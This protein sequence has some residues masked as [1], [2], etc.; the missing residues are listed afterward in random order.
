M[1]NDELLRTD[2]DG[3]ATLTLNRPEAMN[4]LTGEMFEA[5]AEAVTS[6]A[7]APDEVRCV[8]LRGAGGS[9]CAGSDVKQLKE[10]I[11]KGLQTDAVTYAKADVITAL[12]ALPQPVLGAVQGRCYTGGMELIL[13]CDII[14]AADDTRFADTHAKIGGR[15]GWG[16]PQRLARRVGAAAAKEIM[17]TSTP[18]S[19][20]DALRIGLVNR[21]VPAAELVDAVEALAADIVRNPPSSVN[22]LKRVVDEGAAL[23]LDE[24]LAWERTQRG[25]DRKGP[26]RLEEAER[27]MSTGGQTP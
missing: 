26:L 16:L 27:S 17:F 7:A 20:E 23:P 19:A 15:A 11:A 1:A 12:A 6:I 8:I 18:F 24:A 9:F 25:V 13:A 22:W 5:L 2:R 3:V 21:V 14:Y 10:R 4:A